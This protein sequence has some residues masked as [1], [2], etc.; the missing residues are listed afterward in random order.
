[1]YAISSYVRNYQDGLDQCT[2]SLPQSLKEEYDQ[3][4][5]DALDMD[6][7]DGFRDRLKKEGK[8][9]NTN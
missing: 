5:L 1:V 4:K 9:K 8:E 3:N 6:A 7:I 2:A